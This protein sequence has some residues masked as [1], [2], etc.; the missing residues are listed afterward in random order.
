MDNMRKLEPQRMAAIEDEAYAIT[1]RYLAYLAY[2]AE[3][4]PAARRFLFEALRSNPKFLLDPGST[5]TIMAVL[6][7]YLPLRLHRSLAKWVQDLRLTIRRKDRE[8][9]SGHGVSI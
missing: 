6:C 2:E 1:K 4:Y 7:T 3:D 9:V 8:A 5:L